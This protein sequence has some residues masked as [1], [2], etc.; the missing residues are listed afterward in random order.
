M[1]VR[2]QGTCV[3]VLGFGIVSV[4]MLICN[5]V[6]FARDAIVVVFIVIVLVRCQNRFRLLC[7]FLPLP[8]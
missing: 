6:V 4:V 7:L 1:E 3:V 2:F 5:A 8:C